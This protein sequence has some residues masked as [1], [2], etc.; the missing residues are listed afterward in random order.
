VWL[1]LEEL[2]QQPDLDPQLT[3][4]VSSRGQKSW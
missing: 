1:S 4:A 2:S 3:T